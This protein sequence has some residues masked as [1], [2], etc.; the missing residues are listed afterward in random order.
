MPA[1][2]RIRTCLTTANP[3]SVETVGPARKRLLSPWRP[4][5][6][7]AR[8]ERRSSVSETGIKAK[9]PGTAAILLDFGKISMAAD[10]VV[11]EAVSGEPVS[12]QI[13]C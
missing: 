4:K 7:F 6:Q 5:G 12:G 8:L 11:E 3:V 9:G 10:W 2:V 1:L 13:P